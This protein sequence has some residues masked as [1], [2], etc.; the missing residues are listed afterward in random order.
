[1][2]KFL[3][4][5][6]TALSLTI[7][8]VQPVQAGGLSE[9]DIGKLLFGLVAV[10]TLNSAI[11]NRN[12]RQSEPAPQVQTHQPRVHTH[13]QTRVPNRSILPRSCLQRVDTRFGPQRMFTRSCL[14]NSYAHAS[15]LPRAC[16]VRV[17]SN[18]GPVRGY[19]PQCLRDEGYRARRN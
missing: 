9:N 13:Q 2:H 10:A 11:K 3:I 18:Q 4:T 16:A 17:F 12:S 19:D 14:R 15:Q 7:A 8:S 5:S 6:V 1:M